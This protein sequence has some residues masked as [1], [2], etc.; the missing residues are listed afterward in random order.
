MRERRGA[1]VEVR[2]LAGAVREDEG[3]EVVV[4]DWRSAIDG[5]RVLYHASPSGTKR[6]RELLLEVARRSRLVAAMAAAVKRSKEVYPTWAAVL[7][8][9]GSAASVA[10]LQP[11]LARLLNKVDRN[12][13]KGRARFLAALQGYTQSAPMRALL[14]APAAASSD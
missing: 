9:E 10:A 1:T 13:P 14:G 5:L 4:A 2:A 11:H 12:D 6:E 3:D 8:A 7:I